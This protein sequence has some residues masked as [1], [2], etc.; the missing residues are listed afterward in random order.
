MSQSA[1]A[2]SVGRYGIFRAVVANQDLQFRHA[3][4]VFQHGPGYVD[5]FTFEQ[6]QLVVDTFL[7]DLKSVKQMPCPDILGGLGIAQPK[8]LLDSQAVPDTSVVKTL[9]P[10]LSDKLAVGDE[11]IGYTLHRTAL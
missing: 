10:L 6:K 2:L 1:N 3:I 11:G 5:I 4:G 8:V 9:D 7:P